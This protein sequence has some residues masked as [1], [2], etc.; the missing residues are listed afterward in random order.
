MRKISRNTQHGENL[1]AL[2]RGML[3]FLRTGAVFA[4]EDAFSLNPMCGFR[5]NNEHSQVA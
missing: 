2:P 3:L 4:E 5:T 1:T